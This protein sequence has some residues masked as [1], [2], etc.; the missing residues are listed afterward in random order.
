LNESIYKFI[1]KNEDICTHRHT[2]VYMFIYV[3]FDIGT[4]GDLDAAA[5]V[6]VDKHEKD[7][8]SASYTPKK[9]EPLS[10]V[11]AVDQCYKTN[12]TMPIGTHVITVIQKSTEK[13]INIG[14]LMY[15]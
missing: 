15:W 13:Q 11:L 8:R 1:H 7:Y 6:Y 9:T 5:S 4:M 3:F 14:Y 12:Q 2:L 10:L